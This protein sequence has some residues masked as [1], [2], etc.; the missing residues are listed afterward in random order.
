MLRFRII[1]SGQI[2]FCV[3]AFCVRLPAPAFVKLFDTQFRNY[4]NYC[5]TNRN[6]S[7]LFVIF[8]AAFS[9]CLFRGARAIISIQ[10]YFCISF[11]LTAKTFLLFVGFTKCCLLFSFPSTYIFGEWKNMLP[12]LFHYFLANITFESIKVCFFCV[13]PFFNRLIICSQNITIVECTKTGPENI[14]T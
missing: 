7:S 8:H 6:Y 10:F 12:G 5:F 4:W 13:V 1:N 9:I 14:E 2:H 11:L 3:K